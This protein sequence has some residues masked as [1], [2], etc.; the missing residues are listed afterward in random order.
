MDA[1]YL[2][3]ALDEAGFLWYEEPMREFSVTAYKWLGERV[4]IPLL[5]GEVTE[6]AHMSAG[7]FVLLLFVFGG[8]V[9][10]L[11]GWGSVV[12][13][14]LSAVPVLEIFLWGLVGECFWESGE[15]ILCLKALG[16]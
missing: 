16:I 4:R 14:D 7:D 6:G 9:P 12:C 13:V 3:H 15:E 5:L 10:P 2:G 1:V 11:V 8:V